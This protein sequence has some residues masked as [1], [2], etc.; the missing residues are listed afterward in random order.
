MLHNIIHG[1]CTNSKPSSPQGLRLFNLGANF[2]SQLQQCVDQ[3]KPVWFSSVCDY[4]LGVWFGT[5]V[6]A[7]SFFVLHSHSLRGGGGQFHG[8]LPH[9]LAIKC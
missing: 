4:K 1:M 3:R 5:D 6:A 2:A 9:G 7:L 8:S